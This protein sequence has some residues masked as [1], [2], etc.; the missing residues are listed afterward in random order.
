[1]KKQ[2]EKKSRGK[3][4]VARVKERILILG[5]IAGFLILLVS[6]SSFTIYQA[7]SD[8]GALENEVYSHLESVAQSKANR[9]GFF[10][11]ER[12][13]DLVFLANSKEVID[14]LNVREITKP[15]DD[16][17]TFFQEV[18]NYMDLI[19]IDINGEVLWSAKHKEFI[20]RDLNSE[21]YNSSK[22]G[23]VYN[24]VKNDFGVGIFDPGYYGEEGKL[25]IFVTSP[26]LIDSVIAGKKDI[27]GII[28][29]QI[30]N[31]QIEQRVQSDVGLGESG[32]IYLVNRDGTPTTSLLDETG[33]KITSIDTKMYRDCFKDY[34]NYYFE[35]QG[36][37][38]EFVEGSGVY[39][40]YIGKKVF[41][42]HQYILETG[43]CVMVEIEKDKFYDSLKGKGK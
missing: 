24:K 14:L 38:I 1:M 25:S 11:D 27:I 36:E 15:I 43:W 4:N 40:N 17:L 39:E 7:Y 32:K 3:K 19:L 9:I 35:R 34:N 37:E 23:E 18:N 29:L 8:N 12:K 41:G 20:G 22:L 21:E 13:E 2:I 10:L 16:K 33:V 5:I 6:W 28:A 31:S 26:V 30:D 42:A